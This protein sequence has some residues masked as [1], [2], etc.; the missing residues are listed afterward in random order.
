MALREFVDDFAVGERDVSLAVV[1]SEQPPTIDRMFEDVFGEQPVAVSEATRA[2]SESDVVQLRRDGTVV[3]ESALDDVRDAVLAVNSDIYITG[4]RSLADVETP[5][6]VRGLE[7]TRFRV[8]GYPSG[9][10]SKLLLI[11]ISRHIESRALRAGSGT[12]HAGF[13][14]LSRVRDERGTRT[15]YE[16]L[17][18]TDLDVHVYGLGDPALLDPLSVTVHDDA[19]DEIRN[20][21]F[22]AFAPDP[23]TDVDGA[24]LVAVTDD[25][26]EWDGVW[27][28]DTD[29][30]ERVS[31]HLTDA[32]GEERS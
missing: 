16:E 21:W 5:E 3:A 26:R 32:Y 9:S 27:R 29:A 24:A 20:G 14:R 1:N 12:L 11:E 17:T 2:L 22:V 15:A 6:V 13:Q 10:K 31:E 28:L 23:G 19:A 8:R 30:A 25:D 7:G 4:T 18:A